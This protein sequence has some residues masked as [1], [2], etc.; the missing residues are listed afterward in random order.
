MQRFGARTADAAA[1][2]FGAS[3]IS[4]RRFLGAAAAGG[5]ATLL[6]SSRVF[7]A[8][9]PTAPA[10]APDAPV[11]SDSTAIW[12]E[13]SIPELQALLA[14]GELTSRD[15]TKGYLARIANLNPTL[16][17]VIQTNP[18]AIGIAASLDGERHAGKVRGPLHG[19]PILLKDNIATDDFLQTT[20]GSLALVGSQVPG[21]ATLVA[22]LRKAGAIIV[23][24]AN[25][26]E[27]AN[28]R[29]NVPDVDIQLNL[30]LNG[31]SARGG[32]TRDGYVLSWDP[33]G[34]S[35]G[36]A[37]GSS[38]NM[39]A[40]AVG[41][42]TDGSVV[43]PSGN[44]GIV[45]LKPTLGLVSQD[46]IIPISHSQDTA[47][48]MGRT[49]T[50]VAIMLNA[51]VS[52]F[53]PVAGQQLPADYTAFLQRGAL[54]GAR[55]GVDRR[56]F[57][58]ELFA[59]VTLNPVTEA[60]LDVMRSLGATVI[61]I[62]DGPNPL[63]FSDAEFTVLLFDF[64]VDIA[65][66]LSGLRHTSMRTLADLIA[67]NDANCEAEMK[68]FGQEVFLAAEDTDGLS[69]PAYI[70]ARQQCIDLARTNGIDRILAQYNVD[71]VVAPIY[72]FGST[73]PAVAG[74]PNISVPTGVTDDGRPGGFWMYGG[75][76]S[77]PKLL[78]FAY[79]VEQELGGRPLPMELGQLPQLPPD[80]GI[81]AALGSSA[82][83]SGKS[84]RVHLGTGKPLD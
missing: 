37:V 13:K 63:D 77:E 27:W 51:M 52:P 23:G 6:G 64:K 18:Q 59:D 41:T 43:C 42:E 56:L 40:A 65:R 70:A 66:Y 69:D 39:I 36:S 31:W 4:R 16:N 50:D 14:S 61:D 53:G 1:S 15:L 72:S 83:P 7:G 73:A 58:A 38:M 32:F 28:F 54:N 47:G 10:S 48:P 26:S 74:Y 29:G 25:L 62:E 55:I 44:N 33:C 30:F 34:S 71:A 57:T 11:V 60:A 75:F 68:Y 46:G 8:G 45:G 81:C 20:A 78:A 80:A 9:S 17:A 82:A 79:D 21:D 84:H 12:F 19:I 5:A 76:L 35:S 24:K 2:S 22:N 3:A 49:V 67:F